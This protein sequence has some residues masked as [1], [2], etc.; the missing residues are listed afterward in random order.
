MLRRKIGS[1]MR[2]M[3]L[4]V[5]V[6]QSRNRE[7]RNGTR[8]KFGRDPKQNLWKGG[9]SMR[10]KI[11]VS[12]AL[13]FLITIFFIA[14]AVPAGA[15]A[16]K[17]GT[18]MRLEVGNVNIKDVRLA[19]K[20]EIKNGV[21]Y[22]NAAELKAHLEMDP[23]LGRVEV[24]IA[25]PGDS[26]RIVRIEDAYEPMARTGDR[27]G[28][29]PFPGVLGVGMGDGPIGTGVGA[30][31]GSINVLRG[32]A[33]VVSSAGASPEA[34]KPPASF[35]TIL[36]M[37]GKEKVVSD[38]AKTH[39]VAVVTYPAKGLSGEGYRVALRVAGLRAAAYIGKAGENLKPDK[40]EI[41]ELPPL[42]KI[43][44]GMEKLPK[45]A[46]VFMI[47]YGNASPVRDWGANV[48]EPVLYGSAAMEL[49]PIMIHP[50][51]VR[52][53]V[54]AELTGG[55]ESTYAYQ[56]NPVI[57]ELY[58]RHGK[59]LYF[60]GVV[61]IK[62]HFSPTDRER[63][64]AM[65]VK[66][67]AGLMGADGAII[68]KYGGGAPMV[69]AGQLATGLVRAGLK[70]VILPGSYCDMRF[71]QPE[72]FAVVNTGFRKGDVEIGAVKKV[73]GFH[74]AAKQDTGKI[75]T[76]PADII[77]TMNQLGSQCN[78][79]V[80]DPND[81]NQMGDRTNVVVEK[82]GAERAVKML[83][84]QM[85]GKPVKTEVL[86][87]KYPPLKPA[88]V[89]DVSKSKIALIST[90]GL[91]KRDTPQFEG[92]K[93]TTFTPVN[94]KGLSS[95]SKKEWSVLGGGYDNSYGKEDPH[96]MMAIEEL[97]QL[98]KEGKIG[99]I[100]DTMYTTKGLDN[101]WG[102]MINIGQGILA[103]LKAEGVDGV[104]AVST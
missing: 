39:N 11:S 37:T 34:Q 74:S 58:R 38:L 16:S 76:T 100:A 14:G 55:R 46:Y 98:E 85:A 35:G 104:I 77:E 70:T 2:N 72:A 30:G 67:V 42:T 79:C 21:L 90:S 6:S 5:N 13:L 22:V 56:N 80:Q 78:K 45:V 28:E 94:I 10:R 64:V 75:T 19:E 47:E 101:N 61:V 91:W 1:S 32:A 59:D 20:T 96:R 81:W 63:S 40:V 65:V 7:R 25:N 87:S 52:D 92:T 12:L 99:K 89:I 18:A 3:R 69:Y 23:R 51:E 49:M 27:K 102:D 88:P 84:D 33:V 62:D 31:N 50:N 24:D 60:T 17:S 43:P 73:I 8:Q 57:K 53:G 103:M 9:K 97:R 71:N 93:A 29:F 15:A 82:T 83:V 36:Q 44:K 41:F 86:F 48:G 95:F 68:S 4:N 54:V 26:T 66:Q